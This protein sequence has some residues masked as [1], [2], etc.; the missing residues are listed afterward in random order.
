M[1][2]PSLK[3]LAEGAAH[4]IKRYPFEVLFALAGTI[5]ATAEIEL[6]HINREHESWCIR[7]IMMANLG[8]LLSLSATLYTQSLN[9]PANKRRVIKFISALFAASLIFIIDPS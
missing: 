8:L 5:A 3:S 6:R 7:I 9:I 2:F 4:T 1:K